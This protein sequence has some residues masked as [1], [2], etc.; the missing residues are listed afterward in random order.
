MIK[1]TKGKGYKLHSR[2]TGKPLSKKYKTREDALRQE[3][4]IKISQSK[5][6]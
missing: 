5:R 4:A 2:K 1:K 6:R 3:A